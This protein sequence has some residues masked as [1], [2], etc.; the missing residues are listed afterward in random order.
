MN[1]K[2]PPH[3]SPYEQLMT[4]SNEIGLAASSNCTDSLKQLVDALIDAGQGDAVKQACWHPNTISS[5]QLVRRTTDSILTVNNDARLFR[6]DLFVMPVILVVGAQK[7]NILSTV[8]N[9]VKALEGVFESLGV[10]GHCKNFGLANCLTDYE[11]LNQFPLESWR[12]ASQYDESK[13]VTMLDFPEDPIESSSGTET[14][15]L[16]FLCGVALSPISAPSI[17]EASGDIGRWGMKFAETVSAQLSRADCSVLALPRP[18]RPLIKS[19]EEGYWAVR[20][21]GFQLFLSN[22][23]NNARLKF[24]EPDVSIDLSAGGKVLTRLS[25]LFDDSFDRTYG[26]PVAPYES[27]DQILANIDE[28]L[29][30]IGIQRYHLKVAEGEEQIVNCEA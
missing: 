12:L 8:L 1:S 18:P 2:Q 10:L 24:G 6:L 23:L 30:E 13:N 26:F 27:H 17:F 21:I 4:L 3:A 15:H 28:F 7:T 11:A 25:S 16:R 5:G 20:E 9:D 22:A 29:R 14:A 19:L